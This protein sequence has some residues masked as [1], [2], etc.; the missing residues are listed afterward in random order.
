MNKDQLAAL[1]RAAVTVAIGGALLYA[2]GRYLGLGFLA[3]LVVGLLAELAEQL[4]TTML[5]F[6]TRWRLW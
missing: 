2:I 6:P 1:A 4:I 5:R 3:G